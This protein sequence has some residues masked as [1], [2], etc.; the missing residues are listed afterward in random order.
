MN[1]DTGA[2]VWKNELTQ[3][4]LDNARLVAE[5]GRREEAWTRTA[6][7]WCG[8][9]GH[10]RP[11]AHRAVGDYMLSIEDL[12][13]IGNAD[14]TREVSMTCKTG[15]ASFKK[16]SSTV[17]QRD[18]FRRADRWGGREHISLQGDFQVLGHRP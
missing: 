16:H 11:C 14:K 3:L 13:S 12:C 4:N 17:R 10:P 7:A 15:P 9:A 6:G 18:L 5:A 1:S 2:I 8:F